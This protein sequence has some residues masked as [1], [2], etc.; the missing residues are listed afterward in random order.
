[1]SKY[2][3]AMDKIT[4]SSKI[5]LIVIALFLVAALPI[6]SVNATPSEESE[7]F[8]GVEYDWSSIDSDLTNFTGLDLP[9]I[10]TEVMGAADD[11]G[12]D[13]IIG[14]LMT[15]SSNVYVHHSEDISPQTIN[16]YDGETVSVWS[17]TT[18]VTL[19]H[20]GLIDGILNTD[21]S[22][23]TFGME[24]TSFDIDITS[25]SQSILSV[26]ILY[27]EYLDDSYN[28]I[29]ADMVFSMNTETSTNLDIDAVFK[30]DGEELPIDFNAGISFGYSIT[31]SESQ[32]R[33][34][35]P[36]P[37]YVELS[38]NDEYYWGCGEMND[39]GSVIGDYDG[40]V[41]YSFS[42]SGIPTE[43]FGFDSGEF[44]FEVS[45]SLS[46]TEG[47]FDV[48]FSDGFDFHMG[49]DMI[50]DLGDGNG[51]TTQVQTCQNCPPGNPLMFIMMGYVL[52]GAS[53]SF[54]DEVGESFSE[55]LSED[56]TGIFDVS[57]DDDDDYYEDDFW[58]YCDN[59]EMIPYYY[60]NDGYTHCSDGSDEV[61]LY[62]VLRSSTMY[63]DDLGY[64]ALTLGYSTMIQDSVLDM[65]HPGAPMYECLD[66]ETVLDWEY[67][68]DGYEYCPDGDDERNK[69]LEDYYDFI[70]D[71]GTVIGLSLV[72]N[73][74]DDCSG[75]EDEP[76]FEWMELSDWY[77]HEDEVLLPLSEVNDGDIDCSDESDEPYIVN[78]VEYENFYC[79]EEGIY[80]FTSLVND[81]NT[82]CSEGEDESEYGDGET[83]MFECSESEGQIIYLSL[84]NNDEYYDC[85]N[86]EDEAQT[87]ESEIDRT[88]T[89]PDGEVINWDQLND[90]IGDCTD[91]SDEG[92][93]HKYTINH[94]ILSSDGTILHTDSI[95]L[96]EA[97][98]CFDINYPSYYMMT[99]YSPVMDYGTTNFCLITEIV[100][101]KTSQV[102]ATTQPECKDV[103]WGDVIDYSGLDADGMEL[104]YYM[105]VDGSLWATPYDSD[106]ETVITGPSGN[107][108]YSNSDVVSNDYIWDQG[109]IEVTEEGEYCMLITLTQDGK[110]TPY[111]TDSQ[112]VE[113][114]GDGMP[115]DRLEAIAEAFMNSNIDQVL[116]SFGEN[117]QDRLET[118]EPLEQFPYNDGLWSPMWSNQ[119]AAIVGVGVYV[120]SDD[121]SHTLAGPDT[122]GYMDDAPAKM[123]IRYLTGVAASNAANSMESADEL[124]EIVDVEQHD[125][126]QITEELESAGIDTSD[127]VLP[128]QNSDQNSNSE[129]SAEESAD[130]DGLLPFASPLSVLAVIALAGAII[131]GRKENE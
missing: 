69:E 13:L 27:T 16:N 102:I 119:H 8:Y 125:L 88:F 37:I 20:G 21:W 96:C 41:D 106:L 45:D 67:V 114:S 81:G 115:S 122:S 61:D 60:F 84:V 68:N 104:E 65:D 101:D 76:Q 59:G 128:T 103:F 85:M 105:Q 12:L 17:R 75:G 40:A 93:E 24:P 3:K 117:L 52:T 95:D 55:S 118:V 83:S 38:S 23:Q 39:C 2:R 89:C 77:C 86:G 66:Y 120:M 44:D 70:C 4:R 123:S 25:S 71:D 112:C 30:G 54:A 99:D 78:D 47:E 53:E 63:D 109:E 111:D 126:D 98:I 32:W 42:V 79:E 82:D 11:A 73:E 34:G 5:T 18:D 131:S 51:L 62:A 91:F 107:V 19:R 72:N 116:Q 130:D 129:E 108:V 58:L 121:G 92:A 22:E 36:D 43:D 6:G 33:V 97:D 35:T 15:G 80:I 74:N 48:E 28:L 50:V 29:G 64:E 49:D 56:L 110:T 124:D 14:Q 9:E 90:D 7:F 10:F 31:D 46:Q 100:N 1:V 94:N 26:D 57:S 127:L 113:A 87:T